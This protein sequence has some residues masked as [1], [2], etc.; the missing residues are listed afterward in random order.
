[1]HERVELPRDHPLDRAR[2]DLFI[3]AFLFQEI[4]ERRSDP[5]FLIL[6]DRLLDA[7]RTAVAPSVS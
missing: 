4:V 1:V 2:G 3:E 5:S 7:V 6:F